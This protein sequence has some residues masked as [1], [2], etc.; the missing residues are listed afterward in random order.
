MRTTGDTLYT[1]QTNNLKRRVEEHAIHGKRGSKYLKSFLG[2]KLVY[3]ETYPTRGE[4]MRREVEI[5][6]WSHD[7]KE[8]FVKQGKVSLT[9]FNVK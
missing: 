8:A 3:Y 4:A 9:E 2:C 5:K 1:G 7:K 6:R